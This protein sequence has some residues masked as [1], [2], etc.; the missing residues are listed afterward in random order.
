[1]DNPGGDIDLGQITDGGLHPSTLLVDVLPVLPDA[2]VSKGMS[3]EVTRPVRS[4]E[5][6]AWAGGTMKYSN[7]V[8]DITQSGGH[9]IVHVQ[10]RQETRIELRG[11]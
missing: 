1:M 5:G 7:E 11:S 6:W 3:W 4:L 2:P 10:V 8:V 9:S